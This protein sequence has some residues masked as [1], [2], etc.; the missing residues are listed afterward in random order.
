[1]WNIFKINNKDTSGVVLVSLLL[2]LNIFHWV[3]S[4]CLRAK[5]FS[6]DGRLLYLFLILDLVIIALLNSFVIKE[7]WLPLTCFCFSGAWLSKVDRKMF[8]SSYLSPPLNSLVHN[9]F[10]SSYKKSL[11]SKYIKFLQVIVL[12][13]IWQ[14]KSEKIRNQFCDSHWAPW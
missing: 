2:T 12:V 4:I 10:S 6:L 5:K 3:C 13:V 1:M 9:L 14:S 7:G 11:V 8:K